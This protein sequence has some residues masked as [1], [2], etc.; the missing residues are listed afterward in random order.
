MF[1]CD[2]NFTS[3]GESKGL[4]YWFNWFLSLSGRTG[5][6]VTEGAKVAPKVVAR[7]YSQQVVVCESL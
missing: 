7:S 2:G 3:R 1:L 4:S 5:I 6:K